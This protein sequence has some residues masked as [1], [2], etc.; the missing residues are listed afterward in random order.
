MAKRQQPEPI[1]SRQFRSVDEIEQSI[2]KLKRRILEVQQLDLVAVVRD[3]NGAD[4]VVESNVRE[5]IRDVFGG[6][7]PEFDEHR[8]ISI[9]RSEERRV[10]KECR[11]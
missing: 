4:D 7:S 2:E 5:T 1:E 8:H 9:W 6:R 3:E 11:L 10:G